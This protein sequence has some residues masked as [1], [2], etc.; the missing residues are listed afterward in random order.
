M[1]GRPE[2]VG[3]ARAARAAAKAAG[4]SDA[5]A[6]AAA[7][8]V[9]AVVREEQ[10]AAAAAEK[11]RKKKEAARARKEAAAAEAAEAAKADEEKAGPIPDRPALLAMAEAGILSAKL[12]GRS[13]RAAAGAGSSAVAAQKP[14][15]WADLWEESLAGTW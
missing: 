3:E 11:A 10:E 6:K 8:A 5:A 9:A 2:T 7:D 14:G 12:T 13:G 15:G 1:N 4:A